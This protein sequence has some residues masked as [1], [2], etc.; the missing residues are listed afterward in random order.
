MEGEKHDLRC[1]MFAMQRRTFLAV[2]AIFSSCSKAPAPASS[3]LPETLPGGWSKASA[4]PARD[5]P[6]AA[7]QLGVEDSASATYSGAAGTVELS[8]FR[9]RTETNAFDLMQ[10][11][12]QS[13]GPAIYKGAYF[14]VARADKP[15]AA[16]K[17]LQALQ[18]AQ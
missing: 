16:M 11:W 13:D 4:G 2:T 6:P 12:R 8:A 17:L 1:T 18:T 3:A 7:A 9:L 5:I 15:E 14:F 10:R